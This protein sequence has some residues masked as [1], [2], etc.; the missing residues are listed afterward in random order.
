MQKPCI[1]L[2]V[3][4][5]C[6]WLTKGKQTLLCLLS[7]WYKVQKIQKFVVQAARVTLKSEQ[8]LT[9]KHTQTI[10]ET[11]SLSWVKHMFILT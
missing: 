10:Y 5:L 7:V 6:Y 2:K 4:N 11:S 1:K 9:Y 3:N 8:Q